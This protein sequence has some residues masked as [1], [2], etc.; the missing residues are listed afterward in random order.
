MSHILILRDRKARCKGID[1][2]VWP[3]KYTPTQ[4]WPSLMMVL[5]APLLTYWH[6]N[7][8]RKSVY[9]ASSLSCS[10]KT[11]R[12]SKGLLRKR[13][14]LCPATRSLLSRTYYCKQLKVIWGWL[15]VPQVHISCF[16]QRRTRLRRSQVIARSCSCITLAPRIVHRSRIVTSVSRPRVMS[17]CQRNKWM[18]EL[19]QHVIDRPR[20]T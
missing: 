6:P 20:N 10:S 16:P 15:Q 11:R 4:W 9:W 14:I 5:L 7:T 8:I 19:S 17:Y 2:L 18:E 13:A 12:R 1:S 3:T